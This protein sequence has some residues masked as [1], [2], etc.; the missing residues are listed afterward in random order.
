MQEGGEI[1]EKISPLYYDGPN[2]CVDRLIVTEGVEGVKVLLIQRKKGGEWAMPGGFRDRS[3]V[4][5]KVEV[6]DPYKAAGRE[7]REETGVRVQ[8]PVRIVF[9][10]KVDDPR[11]GRGINGEDRYITDMVVG[12]VEREEVV[13]AQMTPGDDAQDVR[14]VSL[15]DPILLNLYAHHTNT[16][17]TSLRAM[18]ATKNLITSP[19]TRR[20][21]Q[22]FLHKV[23]MMRGKK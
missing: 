20:A 7:L 9:E 6:E 13:A 22:N 21:I 1:K 23:D 12:S 4:N 19:M 10:G 5:G 2:H 8:N 18:L 11:N 16:L 17:A 15:S 3:E 14:L